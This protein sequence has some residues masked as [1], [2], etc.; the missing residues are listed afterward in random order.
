MLT[1]SFLRR[2][3]ARLLSPVF[4]ATV[5]ILLLWSPTAQAVSIPWSVA[6][7]PTI[8]PANTGA[9]NLTLNL[10]AAAN[11]IDLTENVNKTIGLQNFNWS[12]SAND[13]R[14]CCDSPSEQKLFIRSCG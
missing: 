6:G 13:R 14:F 8:T 10:I 3:S 2:F 1:L 11:S 9:Y 4:A 12:V 5:A 7:V